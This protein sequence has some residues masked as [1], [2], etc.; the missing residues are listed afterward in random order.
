MYLSRPDGSTRVNWHVLWDCVVIVL[1]NCFPHMMCKKEILTKARKYD[2]MKLI[3]ARC[4]SGKRC[5]LTAPGSGT[6]SWAWV[7]VWVEFHMFLRCTHFLQVLWCPP[8]FK[9][10]SGKW[11]GYTKFPLDVNDRVCVVPCNGLASH[12]GCTPVHFASNLNLVIFIMYHD[13]YMLFFFTT[14]CC[15]ILHT[16]WSEVLDYFSITAPPTASFLFV[17]S[18]T[19]S[20]L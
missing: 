3:A 18:V 17:C 5:C 10:H 2:D 4:R 14:Q 19:L 9:N 8:S 11:M 6:R 7:T 20:F 1:G 15:R 16:D 12:L 13:I